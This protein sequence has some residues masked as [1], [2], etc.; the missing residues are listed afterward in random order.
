MVRPIDFWILTDRHRNGADRSHG[1]FNLEVYMD[2]SRK[3]MNSGPTM[4]ITVQGYEV[5]LH[6]ADKPNPQAAMQVRQALLSICLP[7]KR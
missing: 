2:N 3:K 4:D 5:A 6:F 7:A 1:I